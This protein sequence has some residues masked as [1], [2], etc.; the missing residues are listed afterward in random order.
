MGENKDREKEYKELKPEDFS[1]NINHFKEEIIKEPENPMNYY[2]LAKEYILKIPLRGI[3]SLKEIEELL[4]KSLE[5]AP[6]LWAPKIF[7]GELLLKQDRFE[8]AEKYFREVIKEKPQSV[9]VREYLAKCIEK[10]TGRHE[11]HSEKD[12]LYLFENDLRE[13]IRKVLEN[14]FKDD[15]WRKGIPKKIRSSCV[16]K[17]EEGLD[18]EKNLEPIL[19]A[20]FYDYKDILQCNRAVF[21]QCLN[22]KNWCANLNELE[23]I[24]NVIAHNRNLKNASEKIK[25]CYEEFRVI[26]KKFVVAD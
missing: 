19:F 25:K 17:R 12:L 16:S 11:K 6:E 22:V 15:W 26:M 18:E 2:Y 14:E 3:D 13:F 8:E 21:S 9:S 24:R 20:N 5:L 10:Q 1:P 23:P 7:L 4:K